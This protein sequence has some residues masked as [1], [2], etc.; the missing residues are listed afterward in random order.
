MKYKYPKFILLFFLFACINSNAIEFNT[1]NLRIVM[2]GSEHETVKL[3]VNALSRDFNKVMN[4]NPTIL[5]T[6]PVNSNPVIIILNRSRSQSMVAGRNLKSLNGFESHRIWVDKSLNTVYIDGY[7][8]RG[9][10]YAIYSFSE[11]FLGVPPLWYWSSW[12]PKL[13]SSL[14]IPDDIDLF[15]DSPKVK[16]RTWFPNDTELFYPWT[17][18]L[19]DNNDMWLET[20]LRLKINTIEMA[21]NNGYPGLTPNSRNAVKYGLVLTGHHMSTLGSYF[22]SWSTY[23][24]KIKK[25]SQAPPLSVN[26]ESNL[27][28]FWSYCAQQMVNSGAEFIWQISFRG[29]ADK[30]FWN[31]FIDAPSDSTSRGLLITRMLNLQMGI[32]NQYRNANNPYVRI[33]LY[34][35]IADYFAKN[36]FQLPNDDNLIVTFSAARRD[37]YPY[38]DLQNFN[39]VSS[40]KLGYYFN[41]QF[42]D[43][44]PHLAPAEGP[45]KAE[46]NF[47]YAN[48]KSP[49]FLSCVNAGNLREFLYELDSNA[50]MMWNFESYNSDT[51]NY[52]YA[53][54][55]FGVEKADT[56][57]KT[58]KAYYDSFWEQKK[59]DFPGGMERQYLF[60][61]L[62]FT[63]SYI[64]IPPKFFRTYDAN[65]LTDIIPE[66]I[67]GRSFSIVPEDN[68]ATNQVD[69]II[70]GM[71]HSIPK[72][73]KVVQSCEYILSELPT[74]QQQFFIDNLYGYS[75][76]MYH[77][78]KSFYS[79]VFAYK[80]QSNKTVMLD[81]LFLCSDEYTSAQN[82]LYNTQQGIFSTWYQPESE[83][84]RINVIIK[85]LQKTALCR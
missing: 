80:N 15:Y 8:N 84:P 82:A 74:T 67:P 34:S 18:Q 17:Q 38:F 6:L 13:K 83:I 78:S 32:I 3:A 16:F 29:D 35:E 72:F 41:F 12:T 7:D 53:V 64:R 25:L 62:R 22:G 48:N 65:P 81:H 46:F 2:S 9:T 40:V 75:K 61:D 31:T 70:Y 21:N 73:E 79:L 10:I 60:Q 50:K 11:Q 68:N 33:T 36:K 49:L 20:A 23:W 77:L 63:R 51:F 69:A 54:Q 47:R 37:P 30:P 5:N 57:A 43:T 45:W 19:A 28:E 1:S 66:A 55:Y 71:S 58:Y 24:T 26:N 85:D 59:P 56:I 42:T 27:V 76:Y 44:G 52:S 14:I 39:P 4:I